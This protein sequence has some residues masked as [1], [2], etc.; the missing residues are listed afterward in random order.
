MG[1]GGGDGEWSGVIRVVGMWSG[2]GSS[3]CRGETSR[4]SENSS[5]IYRLISSMFSSS[6]FLVGS[7][8]GGGL[9]MSVGMMDVVQLATTSAVLSCFLVN[10]DFKVAIVLGLW[11]ICPD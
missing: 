2:D 9:S 8:V 11:G 5:S 4:M 6:S 1:G 3:I 10:V 7:L